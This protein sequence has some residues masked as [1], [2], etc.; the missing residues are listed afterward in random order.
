MTTLL[1]RSTPREAARLTLTLLRRRRLDVALTAGLYVLVG[2]AG[3][4]APWQLGA[5]VD[6]VAEGGS[7][8]DVVR[9]ALW[10]LGAGVVVMVG[11]ALATGRLA[12]AGEPALAEL[13]EQALDRAL[14][15]DGATVEEA[16]SGDLLSRVGDDVRLVAQSLTEVVPLLVGS[17][18]AI[19]LTAGGL[20]ALDWR[21]GL[22]GLLTAPAYVRAL[23]W[24]LPRS[25]PLYQREREA[26]GVRAQAFLTGVHGSRTLRA[27]G[28]SAAHQEQVDAAS[29]ASARISLDVVGFFTRFGLRLNRAEL[30]GLL[31]VLV[32]GF[33]LVRAGEASVGE[34]TAAGLY[35]HRLFNP[36]GA[37]LF[38]FDAAQSAGASLTRL[39][40]LALLPARVPPHGTR[41]GTDTTLEVRDLTHE[42]AEGRP[43]VD[44]V[45]LRVPA[46]QRVAVVGASGAGKTT[47]G[48]V[49][50]GRLAPTRGEVLVG[51][52]PADRV[53][54][55]GRAGRPTVALVS[56]EVHVFTGSVRDNLTLAHPGAE[57][58]EVVDA[59]DAVG[60]LGWVRALPEA[61]DTAVGAAAHPLTPAQAQ[62]LAL[63]RVVLADPLVVVLDEATA[64]AGSAG[65]RDLEAAALAVTRGR[66]SLTIAHR[67]TQAAS[68]DRVVV[69]AAGRVVE[70]GPHADLVAA[71]GPYARLWAAWSGTEPAPPAQL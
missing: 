53:V 32:A 45:S 6:T 47:L 40:G 50:A 52:L 3:L 9:S 4:V 28:L 59:L 33:L 61:L 41:A 15:L 36:I 42:Y 30:V 18:L 64:E 24:Y 43:A 20:F 35:F 13:R 54:A 2:L 1:P 22:A 51:G 27:H 26:N 19:V 49:V 31:L 63:A 11:T 69:M 65:A 57:E 66:T 60:A 10:I 70:D 48:S 29:W 55:P 5:V 68:A 39:A 12:R 23:R 14:H 38:L 44:G 25:A 71:G 37:V 17:A 34:V 21:L 58:A 46:G 16:G 56:Q 8:D 62:Q 7:R 67:L